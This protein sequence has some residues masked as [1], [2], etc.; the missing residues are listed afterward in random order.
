MSSAN[1]FRGSALACMLS[2]VLI[3]LFF[4]LNPTRNLA[5][6][7]SD[8]YVAVHLLGLAAAVLGQFGL[9]G[10]YVRQRKQ[11]GALGLIGFAVSFSGL[12][13]LSGEVFFDTYVLPIKGT[14]DVG[15]ATLLFQLTSAFF[16]VG[17]ILFGAAT[18][19]AGVLPRWGALLVTVGSLY[20]VGR[21][22]IPDLVRTVG[23]AAFGLGLVWLGYALWSASGEIAD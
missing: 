3:F 20:G 11:A 2:G 21:L 5:G 17:F 14:L 8:P 22:P 23:A 7:S 6:L 16:V 1:L 13:L 12:A 10:L 9:V 18:L 4:I 19:R 15:P